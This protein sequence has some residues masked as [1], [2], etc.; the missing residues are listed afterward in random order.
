MPTDTDM[1]P[2]PTGRV[3]AQVAGAGAIGQAR[4]GRRGARSQRGQGGRGK[5]MSMRCSLMGGMFVLLAT[6]TTYQQLFLDIIYLKI[7]I[8]VV[9]FESF[10]HVCRPAIQPGPAIAPTQEDQHDV[11]APAEVGQH[12]APF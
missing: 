7:S 4:G 12:D 10:R 1:L 6:R 11:P 3:C 8:L 5:P 2:D 9:T